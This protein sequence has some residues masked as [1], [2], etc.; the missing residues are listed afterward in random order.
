MR[1]LNLLPLALLA[2]HFAHASDPGP[3]RGPRPGRNRA[4][5]NRQRRA[6]RD[7][8]RGGLRR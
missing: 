5:G 8:R 7:Q 3:E 1:P 2:P 4:A 6:R